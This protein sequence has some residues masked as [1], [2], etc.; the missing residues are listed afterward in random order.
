MSMMIMMIMSRSGRQSA[1]EPSRHRSPRRRYISS[2]RPSVPSDRLI[3][4]TDVLLARPA[5]VDGMT[6]DRSKDYVTGRR[7][8]WS[9]GEEAN[10]G[11]S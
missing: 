5:S 1:S 11:R 9:A 8:A 10:A 4:R 2:R 3:R 7:E 6:R